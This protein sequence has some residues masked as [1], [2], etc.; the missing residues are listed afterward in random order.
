MES[1]ASSRPDDGDCL[2]LLATPSP[3]TRGAE[4][5]NQRAS[6]S[7]NNARRTSRHRRS[8]PSGRRLSDARLQKQ[9]HEKP[10]QKQILPK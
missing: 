2:R 7:T 8:H 4:K 6:A 3:R 10:R 5:K 9:I 1:S